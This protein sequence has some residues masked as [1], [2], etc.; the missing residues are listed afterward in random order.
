MAYPG[1]GPSEYS[2][3]KTTRR[4][5]IT[6]EGNGCVR[7]KL[8]DGA[9]TWHYQARPEARELYFLRAKSPVVQDIAWKAQSQL[10]ALY[11]AL[12]RNGKKTSS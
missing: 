4:N 6:R 2:T 12:R 11:R 9:W 7:H 5:G 3:G 8:I 10:T 1:L